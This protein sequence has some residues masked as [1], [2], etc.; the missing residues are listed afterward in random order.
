MTEGFIIADYVYYGYYEEDQVC[1]ETRVKDI[2]PK[3]SLSR[4]GAQVYLQCYL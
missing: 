1:G 2:A 4:F 3:Q